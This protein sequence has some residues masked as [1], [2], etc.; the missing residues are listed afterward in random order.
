VA[1]AGDWSLPLASGDDYELCFTLAPERAASL[2]ALAEAGS[3]ALTIVGR[4]TQSQGLR[5]RRPDGAD[6]AL[7]RRGYDHFPG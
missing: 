4:I 7:E 2:P 6:F 3:V 5:C 1:A